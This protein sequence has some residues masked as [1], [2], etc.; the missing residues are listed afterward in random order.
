VVTPSVYADDPCGGVKEILVNHVEASL[1]DML[2]KAPGPGKFKVSVN[3]DEN[4]VPF[5]HRITYEVNN[6]VLF[7]KN[8]RCEAGAE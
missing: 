7:K 2:T 1:Q 4:G 5:Q 6:K 8:I 3:M